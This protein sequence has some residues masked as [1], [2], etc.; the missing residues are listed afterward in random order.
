[1]YHT[2]LGASHGVA[3]ANRERTAPCDTSLHHR[4]SAALSS[5]RSQPFRQRHPTSLVI[6]KCKA[7][8]VRE[9][10]S[11]GTHVI[12]SASPPPPSPSLARVQK[13]E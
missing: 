9:R 1:M 11:S 13:E 8:L 6:T 7:S 5:T 2:I 4:I 10:L 3:R 12:A